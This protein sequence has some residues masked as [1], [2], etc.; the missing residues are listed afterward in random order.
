MKPR[1]SRP[2]AKARARRPFVGCCPAAFVGLARGADPTRRDHDAR[3]AVHGEGH[4]HDQHLEGDD[5]GATAGGDHP[6]REGGATVHGGRRL[7]QM[8]DD[9]ERERQH[10]R[11]R[12]DGGEIEAPARGRVHGAS[13]IAARER[14][15]SSRRSVGH[16]S[17]WVGAGRAAGQTGPVASETDAAPRPVGGAGDDGRTGVGGGR[18]RTERCY[19]APARPRGDPS[20]PCPTD[21]ARSCCW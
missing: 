5:P 10:A 16:G 1:A 21:L 11:E 3:C 2:V 19:C 8:E 4:E 12:V 17:P 15:S 13:P 6:R 20:L 14:R 7:P 18:R 9:E